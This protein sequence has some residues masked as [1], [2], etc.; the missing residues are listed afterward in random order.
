VIV[1]RFSEGESFLHRLDPRVKLCVAIPYTLV[2]AL[3]NRT[4]VSL[5]ALLISL[6]LLAVSGISIG[7]L[8]RNLTML[9]V[10]IALLWISLPLSIPGEVLFS[11]GPLHASLEG[12]DRALSITLKSLS[13]VF[14]VVVLLGTSTV[15]ALV[16]GL[17]HLR[18]PKKLLYLTFLSYRY[19]HV[20]HHEYMR[21][22]DA[23]K[24]R[25][26]RPGTNLHTYRTYG[27]LIGM[28]LIRSYER[29]ERIHQAMLCRGFHGRF[30]LLDHFHVHRKDILFTIGM[31]LP[32]IGLGLGEWTTLILP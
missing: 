21:L 31:A 17:S 7:Q 30:Y 15:F 12:V 16:H 18:L 5:S 4:P 2:I 6:I 1:E 10:F 24:I 9:F 27:Y 14:L 28:L 11:V 29:S 19:I 20:I 22:R 23:M 25:G 8:L 3:S 13:I 32:L 26:F